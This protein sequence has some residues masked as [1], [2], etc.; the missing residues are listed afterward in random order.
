MNNSILADLKHYIGTVST[1]D[2]FD[3]DIL[4]N[5]NTAFFTLHQLGAGPPKPFNVINAEQT[6]SDFSKDPGIISAVKQYVYLKVRSVFDPPSTSFVIQ[7]NEKVMEELEWR[8]REY[9]SGTIPDNEAE[10]TP[11]PKPF[12]PDILTDP[13]AEA[14][15]NLIFGGGDDPD[16][17]K[18]LIATRPEVKDILNLI[19]GNEDPDNWGALIATKPEI[20]CVLDR[21]FGG[22]GIDTGCTCGQDVASRPEIEALLENIFGCDRKETPNE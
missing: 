7:S 6:W 12:N 22:M 15:L 3:A 17:W 11:P 19:F 9:C 1:Y 5:A 14:I 21:V 16:S 8:I 13:E 2:V 10:E 18:W 20:K 4:M